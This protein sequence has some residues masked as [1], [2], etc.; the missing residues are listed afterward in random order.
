[1]V[2]VVMRWSRAPGE[3]FFRPGALAIMAPYARVLVL[4]KAAWMRDDSL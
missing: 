3:M 4:E 1:M 2:V